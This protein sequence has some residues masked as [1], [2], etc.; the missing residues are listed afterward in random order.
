MW[1]GV[2][3]PRMGYNMATFR[4]YAESKETGIIGK[5]KVVCFIETW[6]NVNVPSKPEAQVRRSWCLLSGNW[7][8]LGNPEGRG[9]GGAI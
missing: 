3:V 1:N 2:I 7:V 5:W 4:K 8:G 9:G 6:E